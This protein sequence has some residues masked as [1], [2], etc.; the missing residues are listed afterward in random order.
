[1]D[2]TSIITSVLT[3]IFSLGTAYFVSKREIAKLH[4]ERKIR[5]QDEVMNLLDPEKKYVLASKRKY[6]PVPGFE[7]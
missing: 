4:E 5:L 7:L 6:V 1:M 3:F 2:P